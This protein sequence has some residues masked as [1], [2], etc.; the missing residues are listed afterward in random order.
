M[1]NGYTS[2]AIGKPPNFTLYMAGLSSYLEVVGMHTYSSDWKRLVIIM[3]VMLIVIIIII[4]II[5]ITINIT[6]IIWQGSLLG[7]DIP[8]VDCFPKDGHVVGV[9]H[10]VYKAHILPESHQAARPLGHLCEERCILVLPICAPPTT[11][12][13]SWDNETITRTLNHHNKTVP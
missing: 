6:I 13:K 10:T 7:C 12:F 9:E 5:I 11:A 1:N 4:T 3:M 8:V 2:K